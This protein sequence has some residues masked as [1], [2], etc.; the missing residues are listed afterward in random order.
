MLKEIIKNATG[1]DLPISGGS[2]M[3]PDD[4][5]IID[6]GDPH[7][8][9]R[10]EMEVV[11]ALST[12][13]GLYWNSISK[14]VVKGL[15]GPLEKLS[16]EVKRVE[17]EQVFTETRSMY[18]DLS[19][20]VPAGERSPIAMIWLGERVGLSLPYELGWLHFT[21]MIDNEVE[22]PGLG[23]SVS[24]EG[25]RLRGTVFVYDRGMEGIDIRIRPDGAH[26]EFMEAASDMQKI[27]GEVREIRDIS[28]PGL[29][30]KVYGVGSAVGVLQL[31]TVSGR[32]ILC[33]LMLEPPV[34]QHSFGCLQQSMSFFTAM[35][36]A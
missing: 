28:K 9:S 30:G 33:R 25:P 34:E 10:I 8:A 1:R 29:Y 31:S 26:R 36:G 14:E 24:Y 2:G 7:A 16:Y 18:F 17:G 27:Y 3:E 12:K 20:A 32:F 15:Y 5:V 22:N 35:V 19:K 13:L 21:G 6:V 11:H 4:P 23:V